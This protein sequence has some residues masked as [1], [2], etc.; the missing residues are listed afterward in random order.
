MADQH[1]LPNYT[2]A[3]LEKAALS[4]FRSL[5]SFLPAECKLGREIWNR[6]TVLCINFEDCPSLVESVQEQSFL[7][8]LVA[9]YLGLA[10]SV[11]FKTG[12]KVA[13]WMSMMPLR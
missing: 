11:L 2:S 13:G 6:S 4:R 3:D 10:D 7:L 9:H 1:F 12:K 8:L 5:I